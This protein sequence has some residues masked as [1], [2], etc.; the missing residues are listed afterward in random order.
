MDPDRKGVV[1][2]R[3]EKYNGRSFNLVYNA[4]Q[5]SVSIDLSSMAHSKTVREMASARRCSY[6]MCYDEGMQRYYL[7]S[8]KR[9]ISFAWQIEDYLTNV[10]G[11]AGEGDVWVIIPLE[12][13]VYFGCYAE[14]AHVGEEHVLVKLK[15][16]EKLDKLRGDNARYFWVAGGAMA[17]DMGMDEGTLLHGFDLRVSMTRL[18][19]KGK[20][21][22]RVEPELDDEG[23]GIGTPKANIPLVY[24]SLWLLLLKHKMLHPVLFLVG[25]PVIGLL[26][27]F[28]MFQANVMREASKV[29]EYAEQQRQ[30]RLLQ[31][32]AQQRE[33][34]Q[35]NFGFFDGSGN[36]RDFL[37]YYDTALFFLREGVSSVSWRDGAIKI[38]GETAVYPA[39]AVKLGKA[40]W[41]FTYRQGGWDLTRGMLFRV[42]KREVGVR[43]EELRPFLLDLGRRT[44]TEV[45]VALDETRGGSFEVATV[46]VAFKG[47]VEGRLLA[48]S[49]VIKDLPFGIKEVS[50][51]LG[52]AGDGGA[53]CSVQFEVRYLL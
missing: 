36:L 3:K 38:S 26:L 45:T 6:G 16:R 13:C 17:E 24:E 41:N 49:E 40:G 9:G 4:V 50:C 28:T 30:A 23:G 11:M 22:E 12:N 29:R 19:K 46:T 14:G 34:L 33:Q 47:S 20:K 18:K 2:F 8:P 43:A 44:L 5:T 1:G 39:D 21:E 27:F 52:A 48:F 31:E 53:T 51:E 37:A 10:A 42:D 15:A 7:L 35:A 25:V 32:Q